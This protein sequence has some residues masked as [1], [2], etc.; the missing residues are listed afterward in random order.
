MDA[1]GEPSR[2]YYRHTRFVALERQ[3]DAEGR[4]ASFASSWTVERQEAAGGSR[5]QQE[6]AGGMEILNSQSDIYKPGQAIE[7]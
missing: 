2:I 4:S 3:A 6:A 7:R 1:R 5:R